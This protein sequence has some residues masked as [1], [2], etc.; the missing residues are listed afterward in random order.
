MSKCN[1]LI[2]FFD[3][4]DIGYNC[5]YCQ[6]HGD[7]K[8]FFNISYLPFIFCF[9][10]VKC[11]QSVDFFFFLKAQKS[12]PRQLERWLL[13]IASFCFFS[14]QFLCH[15][16]SYP[17][18]PFCFLIFLIFFLLFTLAPSSLHLCPQTFFSS[19]PSSPTSYDL[20]RLLIYDY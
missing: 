10:L 1:I 20:F 19:F 14:S 4:K 6:L 7:I 12:S 11:K 5:Q 8:Y 2:S 18:L 9:I 17:S 16:L 15:S 13:Q 3:F